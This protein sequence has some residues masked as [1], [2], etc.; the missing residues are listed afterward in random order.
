[1]KVSNF[2][3]VSLQVNHDSQIFVARRIFHNE[4]S[5]FTHLQIGKSHVDLTRAH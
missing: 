2:Y 5:F 3:L 4:S 1:M